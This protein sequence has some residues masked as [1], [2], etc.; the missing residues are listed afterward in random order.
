M[1]RIMKIIR[2]KSSRLDKSF[3]VFFV[4]VCEKL[5]IWR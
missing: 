4:S 3:N 2:R 1:V 5:V